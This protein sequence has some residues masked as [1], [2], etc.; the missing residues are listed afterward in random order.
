MTGLKAIITGKGERIELRV[1]RIK[2]QI[3]DNYLWIIDHENK[4]HD[5]DLSNGY[6]ITIITERR[7]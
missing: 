2:Y 1:M 3:E 6:E 5:Y 4:Y 7:D